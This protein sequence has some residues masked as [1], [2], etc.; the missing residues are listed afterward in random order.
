MEPLVSPW[1][2]NAVEEIDV[3][4]QRPRP[5]TV[6]FRTVP[7][8]RVRRGARTLRG[9]ALLLALMAVVGQTLTTY[10]VDDAQGFDPYGTG[11]AKFGQYLA[12]L[13]WPLGIAALV[14]AASCFLTAYAARLDLERALPDL[15]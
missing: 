10:W 3:A 9:V 6:R 11:A 12:S 1:S 13:T 7:G 4:D 8:D 15:D 2:S 14:L 5:P